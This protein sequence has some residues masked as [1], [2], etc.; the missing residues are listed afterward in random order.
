MYH[1]L[2]T[3]DLRI[4]VLDE[5]LKKAGH[6]FATD[7]V[8][9]SSVDKSA[10]NNMMTLG[11]YFNLNKESNCARAAANGNTREV[12]LNFIKKFQFPN[13]R[14]TAAYNDAKAD[15]IQLAPMRVIVKLLY[16][17]YLLYGSAVAH[18]TKDEIKYFVF[19]NA[20]VAKR[21]NPDIGSLI[22][23]ILEFRK[24][25]VYPSNV[26]TNE[27]EH[28]WKHEERQI[29][30][31][32]KV[33]QWS[34]CIAEKEDQFVIDNDGLSDK[35]KAGV[36]DIITCTDFW[37]GSTIE[38]YRKYMDIETAEF[39]DS[40]LE[41]SSDNVNIE[42]DNEY[43]RAAKYL[44]QYVSESGFDMQC[45]R[46]DIQSALEEFQTK[47]A[48]DVLAALDDTNLLS[49]IFYTSGDNSDALC[50]WL[51]HKKEIRSLFG[52]I[53]GGSAYKFGLF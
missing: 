25:G 28:E 35:N 44:Q 9:P 30:E 31:M 37:E 32:L 53:A 22:T 13:M 18:L 26:S 27:S 46:A 6:C 7:T 8:P 15:G 10:N 51:E 21:R 23:E 47:F 17:M 2:F 38:S 5:S 36:F 20:N 43:S 45:S 42:D 16:T 12:V 48:P 4:S 14:T 11:F 52:S 19:Y 34:G 24:T 49:T 41:D 33:L 39:D 50:Y 3:N 40:A 29:R 1:Y